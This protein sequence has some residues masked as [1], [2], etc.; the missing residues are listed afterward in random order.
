MGQGAE[1]VTDR[2]PV[3]HRLQILNGLLGGG[4]EPIRFAGH[5]IDY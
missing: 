3:T 1:H 2:P 4:V 5:A